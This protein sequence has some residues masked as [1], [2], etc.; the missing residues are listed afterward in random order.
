MLGAK[1]GG[2]M[3]K[4]IYCQ[5]PSHPD[6]RIAVNLEQ[7]VSISPVRGGSRILY[8]GTESGF[9]VA[10]SPD[11]ILANEGFDTAKRS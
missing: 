6:E 4:W 10:N 5:D 2:D 1:H 11:Q 3:T 9:E 8:A 7:V